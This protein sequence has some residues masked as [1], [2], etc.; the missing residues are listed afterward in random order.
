MDNDPLLE[1]IVNSGDF[2]HEKDKIGGNSPHSPLLLKTVLT[3]QTKWGA[4]GGI[5]PI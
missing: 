5:P 1:Q 3:I 4:M 2:V